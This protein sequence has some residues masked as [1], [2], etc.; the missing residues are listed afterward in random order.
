MSIAHRR[1]SG[2]IRC[3]IGGW[4]YKPWR[5]TF[6]PESLPQKQELA[7]AAS[8]LATIEVNGT[9][10]RTQKPATFARWAEE[11]PAD[12]VLSL[13]APR[14]VVGRHDLAEA[15]GGVARF[16]ES[17]IT[18][19]GDRLGPILWQLPESKVFDADEWAAFLDLLPTRQNGIA[20]RHAVELRHPSFVC[21]EAVRL[22]RKANAAIVYADSDDYPAI[23][24]RTADFVYARL[25]HGDASIATGYSEHALDAWAHRVEAWAQGDM[26]DDLPLT[27]DAEEPASTPRDVFVYFIR[28]GKLRAPQAAMALQHRVDRAP[29]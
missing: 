16:L 8:E 3:G 28:E 27:D 5:G 14:Y 11:T 10:Y 29:V 13:K 12:F 9:F 21:A 4:T 24:D 1:G 19:L 22:C 7:H 2:R 25:Q 6:Y 17:G 23:A 18:E 26:A 20:L 15:G